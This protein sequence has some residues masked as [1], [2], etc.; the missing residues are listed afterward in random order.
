MFYLGHTF[1]TMALLLA[2]CLRPAARL[3][4]RQQRHLRAAAVVAAAQTDSKPRR[5][6]VTG[7]GVVSSLGH[8]PDE[9]YANLLAG[10]SGISLIE[11]WDTCGWLAVCQWCGLAACCCLQVAAALLCCHIVPAAIMLS[12]RRTRSLSE[13]VSSPVMI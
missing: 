2:A 5:V 7:Q 13:V 1:C 11:G 9:F 4:R 12:G 8:S 10:Q 6:V 3:P